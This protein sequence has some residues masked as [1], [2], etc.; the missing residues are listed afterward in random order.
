MGSSGVSS[1][2]T[3]IGAAAIAS[4]GGPPA[5]PGSGR[6]RSVE[7]AAT[8][9]A[10]SSPPPCGAPSRHDH[11]TA[12]S[13]DEADGCRD[14][15][16]H[17]ELGRGRGEEVRERPA[18]PRRSPGVRA[19]SG[20]RRSRPR[21][22][23][24][25]LRTLASRI[26]GIREGRGPGDERGEPVDVHVPAR[27][28]DADAV[29]VAEG[30]RAPRRS[31]A[32][33]PRPPARGPASCR[34]ATKRIRG[35]RST[36]RRRG[37]PHRG[38]GG[39]SR[40]SAV[41]GERRPQA[42]G[43]G[44]RLHADDLVGRERGVKSAADSL[45]LDCE[46]ANAGRRLLHGRERSR[47]ARPPPPAGT[48]TT[49]TSGNVLE[50]LEPHAPRPRDDIRVV[51][52]VEERETALA[53]SASSRPRLADFAGED[54]LGAVAA[55]RT[56]LGRDAVERH[57]DGRPAAPPREPPTRRPA[58]GFPADTAITPAAAT[59]ARG[60]RGGLVCPARLEAAGPLEM[61][62]L[63]VDQ[64][65]SR[66][67]GGMEASRKLLRTYVSCAHLLR[68][69][70]RRLACSVLR[71][72]MFWAFLR[73]SLPHLVFLWFHMH[74][75][76]RARTFLGLHRGTCPCRLTRQQESPYYPCHHVCGKL[77]AYT[78]AMSQNN[79]G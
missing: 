2:S 62:G 11:A 72:G 34:S 1:T 70:N 13:G 37:R 58:R 30:A 7:S 54:H 48:T 12:T 20:A 78:R 14:A 6:S 8:F 55:A 15:V 49:S 39:P 9:A 79:A 10:R 76:F 46:H 59:S 50:D 56:D 21:A 69:P 27:E 44:A 24:A 57:D 64:S 52:R 53:R 42:V 68:I 51:E 43:D 33:P 3:S 41:S 17:S 40:A 67:Q 29:A 65:A 71:T 19:A 66:L 18:H 23:R 28:D 32:K 61:L 16:I 22:R 63:E 25:G 47:T 26:R 77:Y 45:R 36:R 5:A 75:W 35:V 73:R 60:G 4:L 38:S 74:S 31:A